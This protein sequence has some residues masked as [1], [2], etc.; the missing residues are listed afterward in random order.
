MTDEERSRLCRQMVE[1]AGDAL[2]FADRDGVIRLW[3]RAAE[4]IF[5]YREAE[6]VG[7]P[8]TRIIPE[9]RT[10]GG[11][12]RRGSAMSDG[13]MEYGSEAHTAP[14]ATK[15]GERISIEYTVSLLRDR[16]GKATGTVAVVRNATARLHRE[17]ALREKLA[18]LAAGQTAA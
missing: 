16:D 14:A 6:A 13:F 2:I 8:L 4:G 1:D 12:V 11:A 18:F 10:G 17:A 7:L 15:G 3:N 5:G 9:R